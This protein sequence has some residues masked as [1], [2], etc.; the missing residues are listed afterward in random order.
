MNLEGRRRA[1][2]ALALV[3]VALPVLAA[4]SEASGSPAAEP[5]IV[6]LRIDAPVHAMVWSD[7]ARV[8][9]ALTADGRIARIDPAGQSSTAPTARTTLSAPFPDVGEDLVTRATAGGRGYLPQP[10][11]GRIALVN[12]GNLRQV[13]TLQAGPSPSFLAVNSGSDTLLALSEDRSTVTPVD[14]HDHKALPAQHVHAGAE[15]ELDA[16]KRGRRIDYHVAG[17]GGIT[18]YKGNPGAVENES[19]I[20]VSAEKTAGDLTKSSRLYVAEKGSDRLLAVDSKRTE[21]GLEVVAHAS[22]GEPVHDLGVDDTRIY[23]ATEHTLV[24][25][26]TNSYEGYH[27]QM[28][29]IVTTIDFRNALPREARNAPLSGLAV[30]RDRV[31]LSLEGQVDVVSIAKPSI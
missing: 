14:L 4:C 10:H 16:A 1:R 3:V 21:E 30:G 20:A 19:E 18:H 17:P 6:A 24:V 15:A 7:S 25:L 26:E 11:L 23:A 27:D 9:L 12:I 29:T 28:F 31:Y 5:P 13:G 8:L 22:L 2:R